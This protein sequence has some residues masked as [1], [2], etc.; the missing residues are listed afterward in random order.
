MTIGFIDPTVGLLRHRPGGL[1]ALGLPICN[2]LLQFLV[3]DCPK[4]IQDRLI[5]NETILERRLHVVGQILYRCDSCHLTS[6]AA[7]VMAV[8]VVP[9]SV[10]MYARVLVVDPSVRR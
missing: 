1:N 7:V 3:E 2:R 10:L 9:P 5:E 6:Y 8:H 4:L